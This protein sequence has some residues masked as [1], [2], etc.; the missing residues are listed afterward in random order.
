MGFGFQTFGVGLLAN[1][2]EKP[3]SRYGLVAGRRLD[4]RRPN[5]P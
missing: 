1:D 2:Y 4:Q 5:S 3:A